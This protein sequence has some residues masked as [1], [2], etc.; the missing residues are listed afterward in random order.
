MATQTTF[1][2]IKN[3]ELSKK[4]DTLMAENQKKMDAMMTLIAGDNL[5]LLQKNAASGLQKS[6]QNDQNA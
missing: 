1:N 2:N 3:D 6:S 5:A 4:M